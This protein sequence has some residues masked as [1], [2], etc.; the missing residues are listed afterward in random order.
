MDSSSVKRHKKGAGEYY[1]EHDVWDLNYPQVVA[2]ASTL[3]DHLI[4]W[5][6][7]ND[8]GS[9]IMEYGVGSGY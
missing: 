8:V 7:G 4:E 1:C 3:S 5:H 6:C 9:G 2:E